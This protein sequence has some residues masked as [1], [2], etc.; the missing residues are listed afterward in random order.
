MA[1]AEGGADGETLDEFQVRAPQSLRN[2]GRAI[3]LAGYENLAHEASAGVAVARAIPTL[4]PD[5]IRLPGWVTLIIIPHSQEPRPMPSF[6]LR[7]EVQS[8]LEQNGPA[9]IAAA[10]TIHVTGPTYLPVD[11]TA[12]IAPIDVT[13]A[14]EVEQ[15]ARAALENF[16]HPLYGGPGG[17][18]WD[19]G[20]DVFISDIAAVLAE[21]DGVD[22]VEE[23]SLSVNGVMQGDSAHI[24]QG[25][26]VVAGQLQLNLTLAA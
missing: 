1:P 14:G 21:V 19:L 7:E 23:L 15:A 16:L 4:S 11:V 24:P 9:D 3:S 2:R 13:M 10:H 20:R 12:V 26:I 6:G 22:F 8:Y 18:G 17:K 5:G 25:Q